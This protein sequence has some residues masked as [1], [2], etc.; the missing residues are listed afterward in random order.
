MQRILRKLEQYIDSF[1]LPRLH[2]PACQQKCLLLAGVN[3]SDSTFDMDHFLLQNADHLAFFYEFLERQFALYQL[4]RRLMLAIMQLHSGLVLNYSDL[5]QLD[6]PFKELSLLHGFENQVRDVSQQIVDYLQDPSL[7]TCIRMPVAD[8]L[9]YILVESVQQ[10]NFD[11][12]LQRFRLHSIYCEMFN[13]CFTDPEAM[14][15]RIFEL[16]ATE[17]EAPQDASM[18]TF[19]N[20]RKRISRKFLL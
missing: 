2:I 20:V 7:T 11:E 8:H 15:A 16:S 12:I 17:E 14:Y 13:C 18:L 4:D 1:R 5:E 19:E 10:L 3:D 9:R 6:K